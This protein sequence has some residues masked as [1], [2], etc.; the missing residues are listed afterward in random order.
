MLGSA[1][2]NGDV[3][4]GNNV[5]IGCGA[6]IHPGKKVGDDAVVGMG[7]VVFRNVKARTTVIGNPAKVF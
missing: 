4:I 3:T 7:S 1:S 5:L 6:I 2:I